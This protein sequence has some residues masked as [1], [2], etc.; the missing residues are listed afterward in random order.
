MCI[1]Y[2]ALCSYRPAI[3][4]VTPI[5]ASPGRGVRR[6][7]HGHQRGWAFDTKLLKGFCAAALTRIK[8]GELKAL[9]TA[10]ASQASGAKCNSPEFLTRSSPRSPHSERRPG[11]CKPTWSRVHAT[12]QNTTPHDLSPRRHRYQP[13]LNPIN[14]ARKIRI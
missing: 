11:R 10:N 3:C 9:T 12:A 2:T 14:C 1:Y 4:A 7:K 8:A 6:N 5:T 13:K